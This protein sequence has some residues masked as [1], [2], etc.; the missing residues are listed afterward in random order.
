MKVTL[1]FI[2]DGAYDLV[3]AQASGGKQ[4]FG[5]FQP[6]FNEERAE[7]RAEKFGD[8]AGKVFGRIPERI[9]KFKKPRAR[10]LPLD[11]CGNSLL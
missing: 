8:A 10:I 4:S 1:I 3:Y 5:N 9:C 6:L 7:A 2:S 11:L